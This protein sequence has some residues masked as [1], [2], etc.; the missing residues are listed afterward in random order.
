MGE[1]LRSC[2]AKH[3]VHRHRVK[4]RQ[5]CLGMHQWG[6]SVLGAVEALSHWRGVIEEMIFAGDLEPMVA[7]DL[8]LANMF[9]NAEGPSIRS[10]SNK[11][12]KEALPWTS[13]HHLQASTTVLPSGAEF[14]NDRGAEQGDVLGSIQS[15]LALGEARSHHF[16]ASS[17]NGVYACAYDEW[18]ID[19]GQAFVR[20]HLFDAW[21]RSV[22]AAFHTFGA[23]RGEPGSDDIK[24]TCRLICPAGRRADFAGWDTEYVRST[25]KVLDSDGLTTA[26]GAPFGPRSHLDETISSCV[27]KVATL[28][29]AIVDIDHA[30]TELVLTRQCADV[31]KLI[32]HMRING[33][34]IDSSSLSRFD[35]NLRAAVETTLGGDVPDTSWL[36]ATTGVVFG[37]LGFRSAESAVLAAFIASRITSRPLVCTMAQHYVDATGE[38]F[39]KIMQAYDVRTEDALVTLVGLLPP[40]VGVDIVE[41]LADAGDQAALGWQAI[42]DGKEEPLDTSGRAADGRGYPRAAIT[43]ADGEGD[44]EHPI[45]AFMGKTLRM[46][47]LI[48]SALDARSRD[49][50]RKHHE[51]TGNRDAILRLEGL[52]DKEVYHGWLWHL[53]KHHGPV[54]SSEEFLE[55]IRIRLGCAGP[56]EPLPCARCGE[57]LFDSAGS[58]AGCCAFAES[59]RGHYGVV[60]QLLPRVQQCDPSAET[61]VAGLIPGTNLRP[62]DI[63]TKAF[64]NR[65]TTLDVGI[66]SPHALYAGRDCTQA[67]VDRKLD[68]YGQDL[69]NYSGAAEHRVHTNRLEL[70]W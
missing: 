47:A 2:Y 33:N 69:S 63:L 65:I 36:Q 43:P 34:R 10:A 40:D 66:T 64:G 54:L 41:K 31:S 58:H 29:E 61:E 57:V 24:S 15:A 48:T 21:L 4:L 3:V 12:F 51:D 11:H 20:P 1:V 14:S 50:L 68:H 49:E 53:S 67:M 23:T 17:D 59:T 18:Y 38:R 60:K 13:W 30:S 28:R 52:S 7:A 39:D 8:D 5:K 46:Q 9:G 22:D 32:Y 55:V 19:D 6:I 45:V 62:A 25:T 44:A 35:S 16:A 37:D 70:I 26:L 42:V 27:D 56:T